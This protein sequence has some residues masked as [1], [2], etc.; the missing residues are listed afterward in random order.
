MET[1]KE[2]DKEREGR[3]EGERWE[4]KLDAKRCLY[5]PSRV[6]LP[7]SLEPRSRGERYLI[8]HSFS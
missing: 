2:T 4:V 8:R 3:A 1:E 6:G 7:S 5:A